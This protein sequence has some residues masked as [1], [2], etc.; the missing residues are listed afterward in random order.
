MSGQPIGFADADAVHP[1]QHGAAAVA[2]PDPKSPCLDIAH[3]TSPCF[4]NV[5]TTRIKRP[6][7]STALG[8]SM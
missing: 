3:I 7:P 6:L 8:R 5:R 2:T 4:G 1:A